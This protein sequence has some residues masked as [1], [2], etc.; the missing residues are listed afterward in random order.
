MNASVLCQQAWPQLL[1]VVQ[2]SRPGV[3]LLVADK[4]HA[5]QAGRTVVEDV[6]LSS[7]S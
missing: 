2:L 7:E 1:E 6:A 4:R 5:V 3:Q